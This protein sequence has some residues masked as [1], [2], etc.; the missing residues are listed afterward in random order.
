MLNGMFAI[1]LWDQRTQTLYLARDYVGEKPL[2]YIQSGK[3]VFYSSE[4]KSLYQCG[5]IS[6]DL[7]LQAIW[8]MPTFLWIPEPQTIFKDVFAVPKSCYL[9]INSNSIT[10]TSFEYSKK[11]PSI[12][13]LSFGEKRKVIQETLT[14]VIESRLLSDVPVG[15]FLSGGLDSS[16]IAAVSSK[17]IPNI[18]TFTIGFDNIDDP[19]HGKADESQDAEYLGNLLG[20]NH[21]TIKIK[22]NDFRD[23]LGS[24]CFFGD[25]PF[26]VS[27]G[28]GILSICSVA[29]ELGVK[30]LLSGDGADEAFGGYSWY[31]HLTESL[32]SASRYNDGIHFQSLGHSQEKRISEIHKL[33]PSGQAYAW[34]Y[35]A[36]EGLKNSL[37]SPDIKS[38]VYDSKQYF[39]SF[40]SGDWNELDFIAN[41]RDFYFPMEML[42]KA[43]RMGMAHSIE[44]RVPFAAPEI[45]SLS[46][47][48]EITDCISG[49]TLKTALRDAF[50][51]ILPMDVIERPKHG[52]N[53]PID[54][55]LK[56]DWKDLVY[57]T[58]DPNSK[59][60]TMGLLRDNSLAQAL[61]FL[62]SPQ[63]LNGHSIFSFIMLNK[64]LENWQTGFKL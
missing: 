3:D 35:Y 43:D 53:V 23:S 20:T 57:E 4:I 44:V 17:V 63:D 51:D 45:Q 26:S 52:F 40:K 1:S 13:G 64:W 60:S 49:K 8:D 24:F 5:K 54:H 41:D 30:V 50:R 61:K 33:N 28:L 7:N 46:E 32:S 56:N 31:S 19:Y 16:I 39:D 48:L 27:S 14:G 47:E 34:H 29:Q 58:F 18:D 12:K 42:R 10:T 37:F 6:D 11:C 9:S 55:W 21:H 36:N 15:C 38:Q 62:D 25:Q 22:Q 2:Y 59:L